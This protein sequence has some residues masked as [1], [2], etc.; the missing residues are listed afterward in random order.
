MKKLDGVVCKTISMM[1][2]TW[3]DDVVIAKLHED[4][5]SLSTMNR[6]Q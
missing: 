1:E 4:F 3:S 5:L 6:A 2:G